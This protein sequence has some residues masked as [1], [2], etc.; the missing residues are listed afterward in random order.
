MVP[1]SSRRRAAGVGLLSGFPDAPPPPLPPTRR[2]LCVSNPTLNS[3]LFFKVPRRDF[4]PRGSNMCAHVRQESVI[5]LMK[6]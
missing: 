5:N 1:G 2:Q 6:Q 3:S 4:P